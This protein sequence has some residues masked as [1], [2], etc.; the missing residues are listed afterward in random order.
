MHTARKVLTR[1]F[2]AKLGGGVAHVRDALAVLLVAQV[3]AV[4]VAVAAPAHGDA[5]AVH[6]AL[7]LVR[8]AAARR[9]GRCQ[10]TGG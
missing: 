3:H 7:E 6:A 4:G 2:A 1:V 5:Q 9:A 8:V 10:G